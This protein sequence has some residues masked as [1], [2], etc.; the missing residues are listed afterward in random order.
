MC[1]ERLTRIHAFA[2]YPRAH[3][4]P[5]RGG[6]GVAGKQ[7]RGGG[8]HPH[9]TLWLGSITSQQGGCHLHQKGPEEG[10]LPPRRGDNA[11]SP[12]WWG[13][14]GG[15]HTLPTLWGGGGGPHPHRIVGWGWV[16]PPPP[17]TVARAPDPL[18]ARP[19]REPRPLRCASFTD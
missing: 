13:G 4:W 7:G 3:M 18:R 14:G 17:H 12:T 6:R 2:Q 9:P 16:H 11:P 8:P 5:R 15:A 10:V 19:T 1:S